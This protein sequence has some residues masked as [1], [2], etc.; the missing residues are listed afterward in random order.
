LPS[1]SGV[2]EDSGYLTVYAIAA[3]PIITDDLKKLCFLI[4]TVT[5][6]EYTRLNIPEHLNLRSLKRLA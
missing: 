5:I 6:Y 2:L 3:V 1:H 4:T